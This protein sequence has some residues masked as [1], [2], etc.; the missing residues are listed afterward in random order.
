MFSSIF[1]V[2][3]YFHKKWIYIALIGALLIHFGIIMGAWA[4]ADR[5]RRLRREAKESSSR[6]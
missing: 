5:N 6:S 3:P 1:E 2:D 4:Q